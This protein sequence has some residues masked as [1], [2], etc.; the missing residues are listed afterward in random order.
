MH[1]FLSIFFVVAL[2][3]CMSCRNDQS[4]TQPLATAYQLNDSL[5]IFLMIYND[6]FRKLYT[7]SSLA[8]WKLNTYI[9]EGDTVTSRLAQEANEKLAA[10]TGSQQII[11]KA[12]HFLQYKKELTPLQVKQLETILFN[13]AAN[14]EIAGELVKEKIKAQTEQTKLLY[15]FKYK[16]RGKEISTN[17][18]DEQLRTLTDLNKRLEI[19]LASKEVGKVLKP[20]LIKLRELR[21]KTV[22]ALH[23]PDYFSYQVS[24]YNMSAEEMLALCRKFIDEIWP[25]YRELHTWARYELAAR[26]KQPVPDYLPAHWLP[27]R[28]GQ[29]WSALVEVKGFNIDPVLKQRGAEWIVKEAEDFYVSL[30]YP[31][32]PESFWTESSLYP[33]PSNADYKKNN[34]ASA[35]HIDLDQDVRSLMSIEPNTE[36]WSTV[37]HELGHIYY[38]L[39]YSHKENPYILRAGANRAFHEAMGSLMGL[40]SLQPDFLKNKK[41]LPEKVSVENPLLFQLKE[42][43]DYV[44]LIPWS[45]GVMTEFE[46]WLYA[47][48][49]PPEEFNRK[50]WEL[51]KKYQGI[52]PPA[53]R[54][55]TYCDAATKT[56]INDDPAQYYDYALSNILLFQ[57][58]D[59]IANNILHQSPQNTN[60]YGNKAIGDFLRKLMR[61]GA[62]QDWRE[63]LR[64]NLGT[65]MTA[66]PMLAYFEP[67]MLWLKEQ[68]KGRIHTL[69]EKLTYEE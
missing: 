10:F 34:H 33:L 11:Q 69:P 45:A 35:W 51:A 65:E 38:Y 14:P 15:G 12:Q 60:Y 28:W 29:E 13:A 2:W 7:A 5:E 40:A 39:T 18:I 46:Y 27:N 49:L 68:N 42:A 1:A 52:V 16:L 21:N 41:L 61:P 55:E 32:L 57:F 37:L 59:H 23:Y 50:W 19:W 66:A 56:H 63:L 67:L 53:E 6:T 3:L 31:K 30:G 36:W 9:Q 47:K 8:E 20:G 24:E 44:V 58:H 4:S 43:L 54:D 22:Q 17:E 64:A 48:N 25:L 62:T 26:Y